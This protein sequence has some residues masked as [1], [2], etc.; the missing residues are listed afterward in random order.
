MLE[1]AADNDFDLGLAREIAAAMGPQSGAAK[2]LAERERRIEAG[3]DVVLIIHNAEAKIVP[4][5]MTAEAM[6]Q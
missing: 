4:R 3:E 5:S 6:G 2:A 1:N